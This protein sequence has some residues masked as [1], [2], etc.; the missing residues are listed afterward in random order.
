MTEENQ[1][2]GFSRRTVVKGAAWSVPVIAAAVATPLAA[3]SVAG[4]DLVP[5]L[6]G[7]ITLGLG[8]GPIQVASINTPSTLTVN[9]LTAAPSTAGNTV[10]IVYPA[11]LL[12][13]DISGTGV[14]VIG[15]EG[16]FTVTLPSIP[17]NGSLVIQLG[18]LLDSLLDIGILTDLLDGGTPQMVATLVG[19]ANA[20]NNVTSSAI[21]VTLL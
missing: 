8:L 19:D 11:S 13:L 9:N 18:T 6:S 17:A 2:K 5:S 4:A 20:A 21:G 3:A 15:S 16:N 10:N 1:S 14:S 7:P 12:T